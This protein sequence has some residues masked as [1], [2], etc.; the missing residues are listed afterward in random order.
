[1]LAY[2][3]DREILKGKNL[4]GLILIFLTLFLNLKSFSND[5][6]T[7]DVKKVSCKGESDG[8]ITVTVNQGGNF[9]FYWKYPDNSLIT[10][11][12]TTISNLKT[13]H[14]EVVVINESCG[15][16]CNSGKI[17]F[18][19]G[20]TEV[21]K[22]DCDDDD[23]CT[24]CPPPDDF[25]I[26]FFTGGDPN[27]ISGPAGFGIKKWVSVNDV[28]PYTIRFENDP[29]IATAAANK[30]VITH[31]IDKNAD[32][33]SFRLGDIGFRNFTIPIPEN[34]SYYYKRLNL[35]DSIGVI[36][37]ITA[38]L[39]VVKRQAFWI[40]QAFDSETGLP[41][42]NPF[43]GFLA[44]NDSITH[45]GE[46]K[47]RF[48]IKPIQTAN[49]GDTIKAFAKI[50]FDVNDAIL[51]NIE[52]N[53]ID[54]HSPSSR[55]KSI[56]SNGSDKMIVSWYG[57]DDLGGSG[58][59][60]Y[61]LYVSENDEP[62]E[63]KY[64]GIVDSSIIISVCPG[65]KYKFMTIATDNVLNRE[66]LKL[67]GDS[68]ISI[69]PKKFFISPNSDNKYCLG[70][71]LEVKWEDGD[72]K[73]VDLEISADSGKTFN[74]ISE[75]VMVSD[76]K[77]IWNI[78][79]AF[80]AGKYYLLRAITSD[81]KLPIDTSDYFLV[82]NNFNVNAGVDKYL[83][84]GDSLTIGGNIVASNGTAPYSYYWEARDSISNISVSNPMAY[85]DG[86]YILNVLDANGCAN[87]DTINIEIRDLPYLS[88]EGL[89][90][91]YCKN[92]L[93][94]TLNGFPEGGVFNGTGI[95][96]GVFYP[97]IAGIGKHQLTYFYT[98]SNGCKNSISQFVTVNELPSVSFNGMNSNYCL[99]SDTVK[100]KGNPAGGT[101]SGNGILDSLFIPNLAGV[102]THQITY[103]YTDHGGCSNSQTLSVNVIDLSSIA[104]NGFNAKY[105]INADTVDL[106]GF[107]I[108]GT[109]TGN[110]VVDYKFIP[111]KAGAGIHNITY[112]YHDS[113]SG[114]SNSKTQQVEVVDLPNLT[115]SGLDT[116]YCLSANSI[117]I[118]GLPSSGVFTGNGVTGNTFNPSIAGAGL[119]NITYTFTDSNGC[120]NS[121]TEK[122]RVYDIPNVSFA[123]LNPSYCINSGIVQ[124]VGSPVGGT[125]VGNGIIG[126]NFSPFSA[127]I[128]T[129]QVTYRYTDLHACS[130]TFIQ[131]VVVNK[132]PSVSFSGL[133]T[134]YCLNN[135]LV[136]LTGSPLGGRFTGNGIFGNTFSTSVAG[137]GKHTITYS[138]T[139]GN[140]CSKDSFMFVRINQ[141]PIINLGNDIS[142]TTVESATLNAGN[143]YSTY[144][145]S[146]GST[147]QTLALSGAV[148]GKG[149][150]KFWV[151]VADN[152]GC[153][154]TD[155]ILVKVSDNVNIDILNSLVKLQ[156]FPNPSTGLFNLDIEN[157][158]SEN[159][160]VEV[161]NNAGQL[162]YSKKFKGRYED[163][164]AEIN[165]LGK[166][167]GVY[168]LNVKVKR[169]QVTR[170]IVII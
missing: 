27:D 84:I 80:T 106:A 130:N 119:H 101:F 112:Y 159:I 73:Y 166:A 78:P 151:E 6:L 57:C 9:T 124:L 51:T 168:Y 95:S 127:G 66:G 79:K 48:S 170:K 160:Y 52:Y 38:G 81:F 87:S 21:G 107:P 96:G 50:V 74:G 43:L 8:S 88:L 37:D 67:N 63:N 149:T 35:T 111:S 53:T 72:I 7:F 139:D 46:G 39:D 125:F 89:R 141:L 26:P 135:G 92:S 61:N 153:S 42:L 132:L 29:K 161:R 163:I 152:N 33:Y 129:H 14:Y 54:A 32:I 110:G 97:S 10:T 142:I 3:I 23:D 47:V 12:S 167:K 155:T 120:S 55:I 76:K 19:S 140:G 131:S 25:N 90:L 1:M 56:L 15:E 134:S 118:T 113:K 60:D 83:C 91:N 147:N 157:S 85:S 156:V 165:L 68:S 123:G 104:I 154:G 34:S 30:V 143:G 122:V 22:E 164:K 138:Y 28:L 116:A 109:F 150:H 65:Y 105:C 75:F 59:V 64:K 45:K 169:N 18:V 86:E 40:F 145:W 103:S 126:S 58:V 69:I 108:G 100:I 24:N 144:L 148:L 17:C 136:N 5:I 2:K 117:T 20:E 94:D 82:K 71:N 16:E 158:S 99:N 11:S 137:V 13:G 133:D 77:F 36:I 49:T 41:N 115:I 44:I 121:K 31:P 146:D 62:F 102:G 70:S 93:S 128:G 162:V 114:C 98:D 4:K